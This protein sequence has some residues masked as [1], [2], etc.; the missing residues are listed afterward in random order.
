MKKMILLG[1][2]VLIM[3]TACGKEDNV[4]DI[5]PIEPNVVYNQQAFPSIPDIEDNYIAPLNTMV[6]VKSTRSDID[7]LMI[8]LEPILTKGHK[9]FDGYH[10]YRDSEDNLVT[11]IKLIN[12]HYNS[13]ETLIVDEELANFL[14]KVIR[15]SEL[16]RGYFTPFMGN[17]INLYDGKFSPF[18]VANTDPD[19]NLIKEA[20]NSVVPVDKMREVL[21]IDGNTVKFNAYN[22]QESVILNVGAASKGQVANDLDAYL[23]S[24]TDEY[25]VDIGSSNI[26]TNSTKG[27]TV[28]IRSPYNKVASIYTINLTGGYGLSTSGDDNNYYLLEE[29][30]SIIRSHILN[31]FTGY[32]E[33]YYRSVSIISEDSMIADALTTALFNIPEIDEILDIIEAVKAEFN[34]NIELALLKEVD[35]EGQKCDLY[36][37]TGFE[38]LIVEDYITNHIREVHVIGK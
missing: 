16:T 36:M 25:L 13:G 15:L 32:S 1:S 2:L 27:A 26:L 8:N 9:L 37:T 34:V 10:Y 14:N 24:E 22:D 33:N 4:V 31:P 18:P 17:V 7:E 12:D 23:K 21:V 35:Q 20:L 28:G 11:N 29:D 30:P 6:S 19:A 3:L 5:K 38:E